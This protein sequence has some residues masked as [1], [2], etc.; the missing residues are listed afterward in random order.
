MAVI[1]MMSKVYMEGRHVPALTPPS[2]ERQSAQPSQLQGAQI[3]EQ[4]YWDGEYHVHSTDPAYVWLHRQW[5]PRPCPVDTRW[6]GKY[7]VST[8]VPAYV[9]MNNEWVLRPAS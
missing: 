5:V 3:Q 4:F 9:W 7:Y 6:D 8:T 2:S 1:V